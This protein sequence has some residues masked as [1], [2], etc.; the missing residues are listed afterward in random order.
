V[1]LRA[2]L[3]KTGMKFLK[4]LGIFLLIILAI[5]L[6]LGFYLSNQK[7]KIRDEVNTFTKEKFKGDIV[8]GGLNIISLKYF[9]SLAIEIKDVVVKDSLWAVHKNTLIT[10]DNVYA[11]IFPWRVLFGNLEINNLT[12]KNAVLDIHI[13]ENGY[14]N[15]SA[16][17]LRKKK[18][19]KE[20]EK[21]SFISPSIDKIVFQ[22]VTLSSANELKGKSFSLTIKSLKATINQLDNGWDA[23]VKLNSHINDLTFKKKNGSFAKDMDLKSGLELKYDPEA[24]N[25]HITSDDFTLEKNKFTLDANFG[26][27]GLSKFTIKLY[28]P[29][30]LFKEASAIVSDNIKSKLDKFDLKNPI[31][32]TC[33]IS[34]DTK[35][36]QSTEIHVLAPVTGNELTAVDQLF[37][38]CSFIGEF[39]NHY[40]DKGPYDNYNSAI[41]L[42]DFKGK[43]E[44]IPFVTKDLMVFNLKQPIASGS[45]ESNF[46]MIQLNAFFKDDFLKFTKGTAKFN[47]KFKSDVVNLKISKPFIEG[48]ISF[49]SGDFTYVPKNIQ[50]KNNSMNL[51]FTSD[52]LIVKNI[53]LG[54]AQS[55]IEIKGFSNNFM[56]FYY[57]H[58]EKIVLNCE[59]Y[60]KSI[61]LHDFLFLLH[62]SNPKEPVNT[63]KKNNNN[64]SFLRTLLNTQSV[65]AQVKIDELK[66]KKFIGKNV[67][68]QIDIVNEQLILKQASVNSCNGS[69]LIQAKIVSGES[70]N[71]FDLML[72]ANHV[73]AQQFLNSFDNFGSKTITG[74]TIRGVASLSVDVHGKVSKGNFVEKS[75][76]GNISFKLNNGAFVN[77]VPLEKIGKYVF[78]KRDFKNIQFDDLAGNVSIDNGIMTLEPM[79]VNTSVLNLDLAGDYGLKG[80]TDLQVDVH[81]R[82][83]KKDE[84]ELNKEVKEKNRKKGTTIHLNLVDDKK[85]GSK[86]KLRTKNEKL[87]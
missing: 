29:A 74:N 52:K 16:F 83:P 75:M 62:R 80:G 13:D 40:N 37:T 73:D 33:T 55:V 2:S 15:M 79:Q 35:I 87:L 60:S 9:P 23:K 64:N 71:P 43:L 1:I 32:V 45:V 54:T 86:I 11:K 44:S 67:I 25:I 57:N 65:S 49:D 5:Y 24:K 63:I 58:P 31:E 38:D 34:G 18:V 61:N 19:Q 14:S 56:E 30:I 21:P 47:V 7:D 4:I 72:K 81:L 41:L 78:P 20:D 76:K 51:E 59:A 36:A 22:N 26:I 85:G 69:L 42:R 39:T 27:K 66:H 82:N 48:S 28:N 70:N 68:A 17:D 46:D 53:T 50:F 10:A 84:D 3:K 8:I 12:L 77:F 6:A